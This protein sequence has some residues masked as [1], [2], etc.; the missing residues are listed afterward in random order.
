[1]Y[2]SVYG[3]SS[4]K[5]FKSEPKVSDTELSGAEL[6][7]ILVVCGLFLFPLGR[8]AFRFFSSP[9]SYI[10]EHR[11]NV[12]PQLGVAL[13]FGWIGLAFIAMLFLV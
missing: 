3:H 9:S 10:A 13:F 7:A 11:W 8:L 4:I 12:I 5:D 2:P 1:M 6:I